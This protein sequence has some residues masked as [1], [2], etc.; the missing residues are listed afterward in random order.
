MNVTLLRRTCARIA[1]I[2]LDR[3]RS[4]PCAKSKFYLG[5]GDTVEIIRQGGSYNCQG[6][7]WY[8]YYKVDY[9]GV[10]GYVADKYLSC[11]DVAVP[12]PGSD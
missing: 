6:A 4:K 1:N 10:T 7:G 3:C 5:P 11:N 2:S 8:T 12:A 9:D